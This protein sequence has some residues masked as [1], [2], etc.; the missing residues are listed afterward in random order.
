MNVSGI[1]TEYNPFHSGHRWQIDQTRRLLGAD[2][3]VVCVMSGNWVQRADCAILDKWRRAE[4]AVLGGADLILELPTPWAISSAEGFARGAVGL[5]AATGVVETLSFGSEAGELAALEA[6][7]ATLDGPDYPA[8]LRQALNRGLSFAAARQEAV[9]AL[10]GPAADCLSHPNNNLAVE[11]LRALPHGMRAVTVPRAGAGHD[12]SPAG[13][14]ASASWL[15]AQLRD[16]AWDRAAPYLTRP[17]SGEVAD[18]ARCERAILA[19]LRSMT[20]EEAE[21]LPDSG[22][23]LA[24][25]LL[26]AGKAARSLDELYTLI[27]TRRYAHARVRRLV[28]WAFLGLQ[29]ADR[30]ER[31]PYLRVLAMNDRG[32]IVLREMWKHAGL[33]ILTKPAHVRQLSPQ[34]LRLFELEAQCT[35]L[36]ELCL[37]EIRPGGREW[38]TSPIVCCDT[39]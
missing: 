20:L 35:D 33:P 19:R 2:T 14:F 25:R 24:A 28:L 26:A 29:A 17:W 3:A 31:A 23:G 16:G 22:D 36:F 5:L 8:A 21:A 15:R 12:Q 27:K 11:Y 34:A 4:L 13:G 7:A 9:R 6:A 39:P 10:I 1:I 32:R 37:P 30:T 18:L 38:T